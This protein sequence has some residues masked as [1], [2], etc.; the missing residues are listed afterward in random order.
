MEIREASEADVPAIVNLLRASLG[1][2]LMP[3]S[4]TYWKWKHQQNP[5][6][7]SPVLLAAEGDQTIGVR[8]FMRWEWRAQGRLFRAFR[9]V[10]TATHPS[11]QGKG[12]FSKL[13]KALLEA[14]VEDKV[15][16]VFNTPNTKSRPGYLKM[17][18]QDAGR[19]P[20]SI[21]MKRPVHSAL[22]FFGKR[23]EAKSFS[24]GG[25]RNVEILD[26]PDLPGL[27]K[28]HQQLVARTLT[29]PASVDY[30]RWRY[31]NVPVATYYFAAVGQES[32]SAVIVFRLK[33]SRLGTEMRITD[34]FLRSPDF[35][36]QV[37][38]LIMENA[39]CFKADYITTSALS[40]MPR[41]GLPSLTS[42]SGPIVTVRS[43]CQA[44]LS[45]FLT[46]KNWSPSLGDLE[47]F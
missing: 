19:V 6:G 23:E 22:S 35:R 7:A 5:F 24:T 38:E 36:K 46:F 40:V 3:K 1:E 27:L 25:D 30:L 42:Q 43:V 17:G 16:I 14:G 18:W 37:L 20:A 41:L 26:H 44:D 47:L 29:T 2:G 21:R 13:T 10:D 8:A 33:S 31:V 45:D 4:E 34:V 28:A 12:I 15:D 39:S 9:A 11:H 32:L